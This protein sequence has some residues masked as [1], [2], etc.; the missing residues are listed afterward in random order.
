MLFKA[1]RI[2]NLT[3]ARYFAARNFQYLSFNLEENT[4]R[5]LDPIYLRSIMEWVEG[6]HICGEFATA[7]LETALEAVR[8]L[9]L[10]AVEVP[11]SWPDAELEKLADVQVLLRL[12]PDLTPAQAATRMQRASGRV[13]A[14]V[15]YLSDGPVDPD[16]RNLFF[17]YPIFIHADRPT[18]EMLDL[19]NHLR[20]AGL[21]VAGGEEEQVGVK[22]FD[23]LDAL[24]DGVEQLFPV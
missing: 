2:T 6:P 7:P 10:H 5:Y 16:W 14:F 3:D 15:L 20:P 8:F 19:L 23:E 17:Q 11:A 22:G 24:L 1:S 18:Q 4:P 13:R 21:D 12:G 9:G